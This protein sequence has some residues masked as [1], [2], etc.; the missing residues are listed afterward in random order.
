MIQYITST[1]KT[2]ILETLGNGNCISTSYF[3]H[4]LYKF[5]K[6][7]PDLYLEVGKMTRANG[8]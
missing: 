6:P 3:P 5:L 4:I 1:L 2:G 7:T 8:I